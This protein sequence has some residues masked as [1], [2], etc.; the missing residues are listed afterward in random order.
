M[1][2]V[3]AGR[4]GTAL[5]VRAK[6]RGLEVTLLDREALKSPA[7]VLQGPPGQP[8]VVAVRAPDLAAVIHQLPRRRLDDVVLVQNGAIRELIGTLGLQGATRGILYQWSAERGQ[9]FIAA[10]WS[11]FTGPHADHLERWL[12][13]IELPAE[14]VHPMRFVVYEVEKLLWLAVFGWLCRAHQAPVGEVADHHT[15]EVEALV[16]ELLPVTRAAWGVDL[17]PQ[18]IVERLLAWSRSIPSFRASTSEDEWRGGWLQERAR[19]YALD[20]PMFDH[21]RL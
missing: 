20:T 13:A 21:L 5:Q 18:W 16:R 6:A 3:G 1:V 2:V 14:S 15:S 9:D 11:P 19:R 4:I 10:R 7:P 8:I 17:E 12:T